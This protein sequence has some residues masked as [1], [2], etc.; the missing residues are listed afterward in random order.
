MKVILISIL[1]FSSVFAFNF[2]PDQ[3]EIYSQKYGRNLSGFVAVIDQIVRSILTSLDS[4]SKSVRDWIETEIRN[5]QTAVANAEKEFQNFVNRLQAEIE[6]AA[7]DIRPCF[8]GAPEKFEEIGN[9]TRADVEACRASGKSKYEVIQGEINVYRDSNKKLLEG[10]GKYIESC[11]NKPNFGDAIKCGVDA[12]R[13][14]SSTVSAIDEN[15]KAVRTIY[16]TKVR[17]VRDETRKCISDE[18]STAR[19]EI[20]AVIKEISDCIEEKRT[21][22]TS[23]SSTV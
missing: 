13:N 17:Q 11:F 9:D 3:D 6:K 16:Q 21:S 18:I 19:N 20:N 2:D 1:L 5:F 7:E 4:I 23:S 8:D 22:T 12:V 15:N 14:V 10:S